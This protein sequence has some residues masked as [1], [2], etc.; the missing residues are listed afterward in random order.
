M[1]EKRGVVSIGLLVAVAAG[2]GCRKH[3]AGEELAPTTLGEA[4]AAAEKL[5]QRVAIEP[6]GLEAR[7]PA[8][9]TCARSPGNGPTTCSGKSM[10]AQWSLGPAEG[11]DRREERA[12]DLAAAAR[13]EPG[14]GRGGTSFYGRTT[15]AGF[16]G[17]LWGNH[18]SK[19][20]EDWVTFDGRRQVPGH[21]E[22]TL[23][24]SAGGD[25]IDHAL[26][27]AIVVSTREAAAGIARSWPSPG[28]VADRATVERSLASLSDD[29]LLQQ[30]GG[31]WRADAETLSK[32]AEQDGGPARLAELAPG[33]EAAVRALVARRA[34]QL[35]AH[36]G[37]KHAAQAVRIAAV[38]RGWDDAAMEDALDG[39]EA[40]VKAAWAP[41]SRVRQVEAASLMLEA[42]T[43]RKLDARRAALARA[44]AL[45]DTALPEA[46]LDTSGLLVLGRALDTGDPSMVAWVTSCF[47]PV[48]PAVQS[49]VGG[50]FAHDRIARVVT[51][52]QALANGAIRRGVAAM[53]TDRTAFGT[54]R[55]CDEYARA[56]RANGAPQRFDEAAPEK[57]RDARIAEMRA[58]LA[59]RKP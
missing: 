57:E 58:W 43:A 20:P 26:W 18:G 39:V 1:L 34:K 45:F 59:A 55:V 8:D 12:R 28:E 10:G 5:P 48:R 3:S 9:W 31:T 32:P 24:V 15:I 41:D 35:A 21:G 19:R 29:R 40:S 16:D 44:K 56:L 2:A 14:A 7:V 27:A 22:L 13:R 50:G 17:L 54:Y 51:R 37:A 53:L 25:A 42:A 6:Y 38:L 4:R 52:D 11:E 36:E 47:E 23:L 49:V 30:A 46:F 33:G